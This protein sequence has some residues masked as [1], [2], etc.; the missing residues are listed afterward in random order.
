MISKLSGS[1]RMTKGEILAELSGECRH[2]RSL[3]REAGENFILRRE[4]E[5]EAVVS[6]LATLP[7]EKLRAAA[8]DLINEIRNLRIKPAKG[9]L[10][11]LKAL[12]KLI[13]EFTELVIS[14]DDS[15]KGSGKG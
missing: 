2:L 5:I 7:P 11:D 10:K 12:Q 14:A 8:P 1:K 15:D 13:E 6:N 3:V 4:G 9:R